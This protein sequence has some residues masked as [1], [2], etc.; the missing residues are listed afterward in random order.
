MSET[1]LNL[2]AN[3]SRENIDK[4]LLRQKT[5]LLRQSYKLA[6]ILSSGRIHYIVTS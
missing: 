5:D 2:F 1:Y 6:H 4:E 3:V